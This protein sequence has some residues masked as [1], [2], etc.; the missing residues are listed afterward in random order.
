[1]CLLSAVYY[2]WPIITGFYL[3]GWDAPTHI[4]FASG[5]LEDWWSV[6]DPRWYGGYSKTTY[7]P[8]AHQAV[9][10]VTTFVENIELSY[11][12]VLWVLLSISPIAM[13]QFARAF[14]DQRSS[15]IAA[16]L[17]LFAPSTRII[18]FTHG[19]FAGFM[20]LLF[21]MFTVGAVRTYIQEPHFMKGIMIIF[22]IGCSLASHQATNVFFLAPALCLAI[23]AQISYYWS[24]S[25]REIATD[26][27]LKPI[28]CIM[29]GVVISLPFITWLFDFQ[30]QTPI[31]HPSRTDLLKD[32]AVLQIFFLDNYGA[33]LLLVPMVIWHSFRR[34][35]HI[36]LICSFMLFMTLGLGGTTRLP[37]V[38]FGRV[39]EWLTY[40]RFNTWAVILLL[41]I[42]GQVL[43]NAVHEPLFLVGGIVIISL[44][45]P[46]SCLWLIEPERKSTT[47]PLLDLTPVYNSLANDPLCRERYLAL[48]FGHQLPRLSTSTGANGFRLAQVR[49]LWMAYGIQHVAIRS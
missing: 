41:P 29:T 37:S 44:L 45:F 6:W 12:L 21:A 34:K 7:P 16:F 22:L 26:V 23:Y 18:L 30:M 28:L 47:N 25:I 14:V 40:E 36:P 9:A 35:V 49:R 17:F 20:S 33:L 5:Y 48:G 42:A 13:Y 46:A 27:I 31:P 11:G 1:V 2:S 8:L 4:F 19:Q 24:K 32:Y 10:L 15:L 38:L 43:S 39:W 3:R